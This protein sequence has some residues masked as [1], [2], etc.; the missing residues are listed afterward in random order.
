MFW[1]IL[2]ALFFWT[3]W[4]LKRSARKFL[5][6]ILWLKSSLQVGHLTISGLRHSLQMMWWFWHEYTK[7]PGWLVSG[8][9]RHIVHSMSLRA[10]CVAWTSSLSRLKINKPSI[11][12]HLDSWVVSHLAL[13]IGTLRHALGHEFEPHWRQTFLDPSTSM[14]FMIRFGFLIQYYYLSVKF[15]IWIVKQTIEHLRFVAVWSD[16][17][18]IFHIFGL[19]QQWIFLHCH[20]KFA[21]VGVKFYRILNKPFKIAIECSDFVKVTNLVTLVCW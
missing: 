16:G 20:T 13:N 21:K 6:G 11:Q 2:A 1:A 5:W 7:T 18:I 15:V 10:F 8:M 3:N 9:A 17:Y 4:Q 14:L 19:K 12:G